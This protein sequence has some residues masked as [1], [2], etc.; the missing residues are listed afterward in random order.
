MKKAT[1]MFGLVMLVA[2]CVLVFAQ[3]KPVGP[4][5]T[6][7]VDGVGAPFPWEAVLRVVGSNLIGAVST[8]SLDSTSE[9]IDGRIDGDTIT[10]KF[11]PFDGRARTIVLTGKV[12]DDTI[13]FT[14]ESQDPVGN[15]LPAADPMFGAS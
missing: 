7:R 6:W 1:Y 9:I 2:A 13:T 8:R 11:N 3:T 4:T 12:N 15:A 5:G 14:W 10:F